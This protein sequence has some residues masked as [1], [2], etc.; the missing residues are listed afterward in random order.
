VTEKPLSGDHP[1]PLPVR[2][3]LL[4]LAATLA[5]LLSAGIVITSDLAVG[6]RASAPKAIVTEL[7]G[8]WTLLLALLPA[9]PFMRRRP[10]EGPRWPARLLLHVGLSAAV[11]ATHTL[12]M[13][14]VRSALFPLLGWGRYDYGDMRFRLPMEYQKQAAV[15]LL[16]Y[17]LV[18]LVVWLRRSREAELEASELSRQL[19][20]ARLAALKRQL[21]PHF[22]FN[23]L[24]TVSAFVRED[25]ARAEAMIGHLSAFLRETLRH[26]DAVE[27]PLGRELAFLSSWLAIMK[28]RFEDRLDV[29]VDV[30]PETLGV[31]VPHLVLQPLVENSV[32]HGADLGPI[33]VRVSAERCGERLRLVVSDSGPG[34]GGSPADALGRGTGLSNTAQRLRALH[35]DDQRL[36]LSNGPDGGLV[37]TVEMPWRESA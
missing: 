26:A 32:R 27:V 33:R 24:N 35:A 37:V 19:T 15:Y 14:G 16:V 4:I 2:S 10:V 22:L 1:G 11:G 12:L 6:Q 34:L 29:A 25:P 13:W 8:A 9:L 5:G 36:D 17:G 18:R 31:L 21:E 20:E 30:P 3:E 23:A 28:A 7:T